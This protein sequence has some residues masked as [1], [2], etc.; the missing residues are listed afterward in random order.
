MMDH[1]LKLDISMVHVQ[2]GEDAKFKT[3]GCGSA[4]ASSSYASW[5]NEIGR[6]LGD[7]E[8]TMEI[9]MKSPGETMKSP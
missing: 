1:P 7:G 3:F 8:F 4:I 9:T 2:P 6:I 5:P